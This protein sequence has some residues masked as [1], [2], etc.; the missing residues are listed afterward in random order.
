M[1]VKVLELVSDAATSERAS[2][3]AVL[4]TVL[5]A[6]PGQ[7]SDPLAGV[8]RLTDLSRF[9]SH[10]L[11]LVLG[12]HVHHGRH[13]S[14][15]AADDSASSSAAEQQPVK[16]RR[17]LRRLQSSPGSD[18]DGD[19]A[20]SSSSMH[21]DDEDA[22]EKQ[23]GDDTIRWLG[24][25]IEED[26][27]EEEDTAD[28]GSAA[29]GKDAKR[30]SSSPRGKKEKS[31]AHVA[32][33]SLLLSVGD[34]VAVRLT[35][36]DDDDDESRRP[37]LARIDR[38]VATTGGSDDG[39]VHVT[40][41]YKVGELPSTIDI[42]AFDLDPDG[43]D[44]YVLSNH[45]DQLSL[46]CIEAVHNNDYAL[47]VHV[48]LDSGELSWLEDGEGGGRGSLTARSR[49]ADSLDSFVDCLAATPE[50]RDETTFWRRATDVFLRPTAD[51]GHAS[52]PQRAVLREADYGVRFE[53]LVTPVRARCYCC[54]ATRSCTHRV[55]DVAAAPP[56]SDRKRAANSGGGEAAAAERFAGRFCHLRVTAIQR[57]LT[58]MEQSTMAFQRPGP[59]MSR[60]AL[61]TAWRKAKQCLAA[62]EHTISYAA[63]SSS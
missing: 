33:G 49:A 19:D 39:Q 2:P 8:K 38:L 53:P 13:G 31:Y 41:C 3:L 54:N 17:R 37:D 61:T 51:I 14:K 12:M 18:R 6:I 10:D 28:R 45:T 56:Q 25:P 59:P 29:D 58:H 46:R 5:A 55:V 23:S 40:W 9:T 48:D 1:D 36:S 16:K 27:E 7:P 60:D 20:S 21:D 57:F 62:T 42:A 35:E 50:R 4:D 26:D 30:S 34:L 52:N 43:D 24:A 22:K 11:G 15:R 44:D 63:A 32:V 47:L